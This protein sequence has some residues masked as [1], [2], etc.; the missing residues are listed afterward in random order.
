MHVIDSLLLLNDSA[1]DAHDL[2]K[3]VWWVA[4]GDEISIGDDEKSEVWVRSECGIMYSK[5]C[6][7]SPKLETL[8]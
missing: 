3:D 8:S 2:N 1:V 7:D 5:G 6:G 4:D